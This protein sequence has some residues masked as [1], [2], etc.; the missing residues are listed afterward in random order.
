MASTE[1]AIH[2]LLTRIHQAWDQKYVASL[3]LLDV[4]GAFDNVS[5]PRLLHNLR[6]RK[7]DL[8]TVRW[9]ASFLSNRV[10]TVV[11]PEFTAEECAVDTGIPQGVVNVILQVYPINL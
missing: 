6:K 7:I 4:S 5:H 8:I 11:L 3:L 10:T 1:H 2:Q 9:I